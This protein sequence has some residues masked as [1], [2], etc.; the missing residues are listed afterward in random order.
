MSFLWYTARLFPHPMCFCIGGAEKLV[1]GPFLFQSAEWVS[2]PEN[3]ILG[4]HFARMMGGLKVWLFC[5]SYIFV[6]G[7]IYQLTFG[8]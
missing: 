8:V 6:S 3:P 2:N 5:D 4:Q 7:V 1:S